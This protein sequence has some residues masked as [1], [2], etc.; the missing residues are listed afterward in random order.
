[1]K[2]ALNPLSSRTH[3]VP[4][5][6]GALPSFIRFW[7]ALG[8]LDELGTLLVFGRLPEARHRQVILM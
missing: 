7:A 3:S 8:S 2:R 5:R 4:V 1:M 6:R